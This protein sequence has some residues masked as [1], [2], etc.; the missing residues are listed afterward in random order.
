MRIIYGINPVMEALD[1]G[2]SRIDEILVSAKRRDKSL[3]ALLKKAADKKVRVSRVDPRRLAEAA[4]T[5][6]NQGIVALF[7]G[8]YPY[9]GIEEV[10]DNWRA[11]GES[12]FVL[13]LDCIQDPQNLGSLVRAAHC[14]GVHGIVIPK[15]R[16]AQVTP[17][18]VKASAGATEHTLIARVTNLRDAIKRLKDEGVWIAGIEATFDD[19][20][21]NTELDGDIGIVIGSEGSGMRR[22]IR[23]E[24]D[25][26]VNIPMKGRVNSLNAAQAGAV[27]LFETARQKE[28][29]GG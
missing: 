15:D 21:Y 16:A 5:E 12:A 18:V 14:A 4:G 28:A 19:T 7:K 22:L 20:I 27:A 13:I 24:C 6:R 29:S 3:D 1:S 8:E 17:A 26:C 23:E 2:R 25:F 9:C 10:V 11:S